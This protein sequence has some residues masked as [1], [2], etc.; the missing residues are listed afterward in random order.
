MLEVKISVIIVTKNSAALLEQCLKKIKSQD[1]DHKILEI[2]VV[3]GSS[4]D[5]TMQKCKENNAS[6][7]DGGYPENQEARRLVGARIAKGTVLVFIDTDNFIEDKSWI[8]KMVDPVTKLGADCSFTKWYEWR[9]DLS[10]LDRYY[11]LI[12]GNDPVAYYLGKNDRV[13]YLSNKLPIGAKLNKTINGIDFVEF[14]SNNMP[15]IGCNGFVM[16]S[17]LIKDLNISDPNLFFHT[18]IHVDLLKKRKMIYA[19]VQIS[20]T[21]AAGT[22]L[23]Q[24]IRKRLKYKNT[25]GEKETRRYLVFNISNARDRI[26]LIKI[27]L[28]CILILPLIFDSIKGY[29]RT[30]KKSGFCIRL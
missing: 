4:T 7:I 10:I 19:I 22:T 23:L 15:T 5:D 30:G 13:E 20:I 26:N 29:I 28:R 21:H 1:I 14:N 11:A 8:S 12:G 2:L 27:I 9:K 3:D 24:S 17:S 6:Y 25:H 16:K 18:D